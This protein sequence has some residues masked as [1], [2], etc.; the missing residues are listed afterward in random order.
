MKMIKKLSNIKNPRV[1]VLMPAYN[2]EK[3]IGESI[4]SILGQTF[5]DFELIIVNDGSTDNTAEI[6]RKYARQDT[7]IKFIDNKKNAGVA[8]T[9]NQLLDAACG[10]YIAFQDSDDISRPYRLATQVKFLDSHPDISV[11]GAAMETFPEYETVSYIENP[12]LLDFYIANAVSN[13]VVMFRKS[14]I[15]KYGF[16]YNEK[17]QT[18]EDYDFWVRVVRVLKIHNLRDVLINYRV[19]P[20]SLSHNNP[21]LDYFNKIIRDGIINNLTDNKIM[22]LLISQKYN[23]KLFGF[24]PL[25]RIKRRRIYLFGFLPFLIRREMWWWLFGIIPFIKIQGYEQ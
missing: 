22:Q 23:T 18:C 5:D 9:R 24:I 25:L 21:K 20:Q 1:S 19:L 10:E 13:A 15:D 17:Y 2:A 6:V 3:Y 14:D 4:D 7:R 16:R 12:K 11:L 8:K